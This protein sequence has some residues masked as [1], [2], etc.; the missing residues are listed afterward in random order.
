MLH[1]TPFR[2]LR[3][4]LLGVFAVSF[5][6][7]CSDSDS[8][9]ITP[10]PA[11]AN[12]GTATLEIFHASQDAPPVTASVAGNPL[13]AGALLDFGGVLNTSVTGGTFSLAVDGQL[14]G[15]P[16]TVIGPAD[17]T[18]T[19]GQRVSVLALNDVANIEPLIIIEDGATVAATD[20]RVR[21]VHAA[22][23]APLVD[24]Y[25]TDP[26]TDISTVAPL[27]TFAFKDVLGPATVTE[28]D[29]RIQVTVAGD[30]TTVVYDSGTVALAG[31]SDLLIAAIANVAT[32]SAAIE[33][34]ASTGSASLRLLDTNTPA[35]LRVVHVSPDAPNVDVIAA[36][37][38]AAPAVSNLAYPEATG[39]LSLTPGDLNVKVVPTGATTPV[40]IDADVTLEAAT[41]YS[42]LAVGALADIAPLVLVDDVRRVN[43]EARVRIIHGSPSAG[44]VDIFVVAPGTDITT[45]TPAFSAVPFQAET[46]YVSLE[47]G[48]YDVVVTPTGTTTAAI[49]PVTISIANGGIYTAIARDEVGLGTPL[50][51][52]LLDDF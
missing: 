19:D 7:A 44:D 25:V 50:G 48:D 11:N 27:G 43:T 30:P 6:A 23:S 17:I 42:V 26:T 9:T 46:G 47:A 1:L 2:Q 37:N 10:P 16:A 36:D 52:I 5:I 12:L 51:L 33:L 14:P 4:L 31:G 8:G 40:V 3:R 39:Y 15:G 18:A 45:A 49:G 22:S 20:V 29:Y 13:A 28:G 38:F 21:V 34:I 35:D 24:V 41:S 32:G